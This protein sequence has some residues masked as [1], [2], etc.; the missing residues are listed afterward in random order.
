MAHLASNYTS[1]ETF[2]QRADSFWTVDLGALNSSGVEGTAILAVVTDDDGS[3]YLNVAISATGLTPS[4]THAQHIHGLFDGAGAPIDSVAPTIADDAD[5]DGMVEVLEGVG[6][7][8]DVLLPLSS[9]G[10]MPMADANGN[11]FFVQSYD[12]GDDSNFFS[13]VTMTDY[14]AADIMPLALREIVLHG[15]EIPD[16][17]GMGTGGE[18]AGGANGYI[19]IL[20]AAAGD[21]EVATQEEALALLE[22]HREIA[23]DTVVLTPDADM[24]DGGRGDDMIDGLAGNDTITGGADN[25]TL[26]GGM[27]ADILE[28]NGGDDMVDA[29]QMDMNVANAA[30]AGASGGLTL[31]EYDSGIAG[32]AGNDMIMGGAG[33]EILTGD[34]DSRTAE[35]TGSVFDAMADG[36][37]TIHGGGGNDE[38]HTGSWSDSDQ[39]LPN[40]QTGMMADVA[41]GDGGDDILRG[42][43]GND[44]LF[45]NM[46]SDNIGGGGGDDMIYGD[47]AFTGDITGIT[48]Q[49][50]RLYTSS[51]D[52]DP[53]APGFESWATSLGGGEVN[54]NRVATGFSNSPEFQALYGG[55]TNEDFVRAMYQNTLDRGADPGGLAHWTGLLDAGASRAEVLLGFSES[56]E[57]KALS[58]SDMVDWVD[59]QGTNDVLAGNGGANTLSGGYLSDTFVFGTDGGSSHNVTDLESWDMLDFTAFGYAD[60]DAAIAQMMQQGDDVVFSDQDVIVTL[61]DTQLT[62]VSGDMVLV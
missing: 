57:L 58:A 51:F 59:A 23:S 31:A 13:P 55:G 38:I 12:L 18:V 37:D 35:V 10:M 33:D 36:M 44:M 52:R 25:D 43:G 42:A 27:G 19:G 61:E 34:D 22:E 29:G 9:G 15:V 26:L 8:G 5:R 1:F 6:Q 14:T 20:P 24:F 17:I 54:L 41:Y 3:S 7:Y 2:L 53:D 47:S 62:Q 40:A 16:G 30:D 45:G 50:Y 60:A 11:V 21:I 48:G 4:Q 46:G 28:G 49:L 56:A 32:G 39:G